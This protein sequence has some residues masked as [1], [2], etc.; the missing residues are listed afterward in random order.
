VSSS[1]HPTH[2]E[3]YS[4][5]ARACYYGNSYKLAGMLAIVHALAC[6]RNPQS[7]DWGKFYYEGVGLLLGKRYPEAKLFGGVYF[8]FFRGS[9]F[10]NPENADKRITYCGPFLQLHRV[11]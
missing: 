10:I 2:G 7:H 1:D 5:T 9:E 8:H 6:T 11:K 4:C 3:K